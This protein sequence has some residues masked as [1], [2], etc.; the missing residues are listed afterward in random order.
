[1]IQTLCIL[2]NL[3]CFLHL[4]MFFSSFPENFSTSNG[5]IQI[6]PNILS[7]L[8]WVQTICEGYQ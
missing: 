5:L 3:A 6:K 4:Q 1:M 2:G 8:M 7:G